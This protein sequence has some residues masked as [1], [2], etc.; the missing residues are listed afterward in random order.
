MISRLNLTN[1]RNHRQFSLTIDRD[2]VGLAGSNGVGKT[3]ILE[4]LSLFAPGRGLRGARLEQLSF[5]PELNR[6]QTRRDLDNNSAIIS[7]IQ[8]HW[9]V[10][11]QLQDGHKIGAGLELNRDGNPKRVLRLNGSNCNSEAISDLVRLAWL[12][13]RHDRLFAESGSIRRRFLDRLIA[14][15]DPSHAHS[16]ARYERAM[17]QR[18]KLLADVN[19]KQHKPWLDAIE[20]ELAQAGTAMAAARVSLIARLNHL[21]HGEFSPPDRS[22]GSLSY[23]SFAK[24]Q[25]ALS[26]SVESQIAAGKDLLDLEQWLRVTYERDRL[27]EA[28]TGRTLT[29]PHRTEL[30]AKHAGKDIDAKLCSTG[31]QKAM[32]ISLFLANAHLLLR[33]QPDLPFLLLLDEGFAHLDP[34]KRQ[35]L[36]SELRALKMQSWVTSAD[37]ALFS[38]MNG[39]MQ[40]QILG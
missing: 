26:G 6:G 27:R 9:T 35:A 16:A 2:I 36:V 19:H 4:A 24:P 1:F 13:P 14:A 39:K 38:D 29:G 18:N 17:R 11:A 32:V 10:F 31:E 12:T 15:H 8:M 22:A 34:E 25:L 40:L 20:L 30:T 33:D 37:P 3:N 7:S 23:T 21:M 5:D 28:G